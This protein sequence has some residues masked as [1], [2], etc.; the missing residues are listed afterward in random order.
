MTLKTEKEVETTREKLL[1]L[2]RAYAEA[3]DESPVDDHTR[4]LTLQSLAHLM[5]QLK[6]EITRY[7][8]RT[9]SSTKGEPTPVSPN[10]ARPIAKRRP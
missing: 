2:E 7:E 4:K 5:N 10:V 1:L 9:R 8:V 3:R 6:E